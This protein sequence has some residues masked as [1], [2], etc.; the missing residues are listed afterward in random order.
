MPLLVETGQTD[1]FDR[2]AVVDVPVE[3]QLERLMARDGSDEVQARAILTAQA[4]REARLAVADDV[5]DNDGPIERT[6][7][8]VDELHGR[9]TT[10]NFGK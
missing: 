1:R 6:L 5:I 2:I 9:Y 4:T 8:R 10:L 3:V 7:A